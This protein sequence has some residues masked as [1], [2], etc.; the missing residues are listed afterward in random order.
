MYSSVCEYNDNKGFSIYIVFLFT[1][2][3]KEVI[4]FTVGYLCLAHA[5]CAGDSEGHRQAVADWHPLYAFNWGNVEKFQALKTAWGQQ[6][7][8]D[9]LWRQL[10]F[11]LPII[12]I[13]V[14]QLAQ[15]A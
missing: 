7:T 11:A 13:W 10:W 4:L 3:L 8:S 12:L 5:P 15:A 9:S 2:S 14:A 6:V 1:A